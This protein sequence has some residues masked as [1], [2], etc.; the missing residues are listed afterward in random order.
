VIALPIMAVVVPLFTAPDI[1]RMVHYVQKRMLTKNAVKVS[2]FC[3][4][5]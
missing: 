2:W 4:A 1:G 5:Q 3:L